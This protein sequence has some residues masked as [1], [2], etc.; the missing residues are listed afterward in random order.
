MI[1]ELVELT[2]A[3]LSVTPGESLDL[4]FGEVHDFELNLPH[5]QH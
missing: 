4:V 5:S 3:S 1:A 2:L